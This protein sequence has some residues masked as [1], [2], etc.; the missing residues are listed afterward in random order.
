MNKEI[1]TPIQETM[2]I[3]GKNKIEKSATKDDVTVKVS[4]VEVENGYI[5]NKNISG[6]RPT[7]DASAEDGKEYFNEDLTY[8]TTKCPFEDEMKDI[9]FPDVTN[10]LDMSASLMGKIKV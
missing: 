6:R 1:A 7:K 3:E 4:C 5:L 2:Y 8:I 10:V 9:E